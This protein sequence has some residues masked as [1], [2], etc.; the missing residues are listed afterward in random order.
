VII[1]FTIERGAQV[2]Q[3][4]VL[5]VVRASSTGN[6]PQ[7]NNN[8]AWVL[9]STLQSLGVIVAGSGSFSLSAT[10][11]LNFA[12][13]NFAADSLQAQGAV[14][15][16]SGIWTVNSVLGTGSFSGQPSSFTS[17]S[18][19]AQQFT[20]NDGLLNFGKANIQTATFQN[21]VVSVTTGIFGT[22]NFQGGTLQGLGSGKSSAA[23]TN[24]VVTTPPAKTLK[25]IDV[26]AKKLSL[27]CGDGQC[28]LL[29]LGATLSTGK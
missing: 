12:N 1:F 8:G 13:A 3:G 22:L 25:N 6:P 11:V 17:N 15:I 24:F 29:T 26:S 23:I 14:Q 19:T 7:I 9:A 4:S 21:G 27:S 28:A 2:S 10:G 20:L 18:F 5:K 16:Q